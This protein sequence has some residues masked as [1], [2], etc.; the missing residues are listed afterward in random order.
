MT[1]ITIRNVPPEVR[2]EL[3]SRAARAGQ[4]LQEHLRAQL[5]E[6]ASRPT[7]G[8]LLER[9]R[10]RAR[11]TATYLSVEEVLADRDADRT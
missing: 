10:A 3:A 4:S 7:V 1:S 2:N 5:I 6:L 9:A 11:A 8:D